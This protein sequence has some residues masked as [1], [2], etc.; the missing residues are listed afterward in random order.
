MNEPANFGTNEERPWNWPEDA[1]P[2]WSLKCPEEPLEDPVYRTSMFV[3][4]FTTYFNTLLPCFLIEAGA[5]KFKLARA[6]ALAKTISKNYGI[7]QKYEFWVSDEHSTLI[8]YNMLGKTKIIDSCHL[9]VKIRAFLSK[10]VSIASYK[11]VLPTTRRKF[12]SMQ[13]EIFN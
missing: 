13:G 12:M 9:N 11:S 6:P 3:V 10:L 5:F 8:F 1:R 2:Y 7:V 4:Y